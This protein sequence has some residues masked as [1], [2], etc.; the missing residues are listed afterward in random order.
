MKC[1]MNMGENRSG[2]A[3]KGLSLAYDESLKSEPCL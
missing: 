3:L 2:Q 1:D